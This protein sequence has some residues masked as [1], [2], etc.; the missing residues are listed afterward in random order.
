MVQIRC[1]GGRR[2]GL[3]EHRT[4]GLIVLICNRKRNFPPG[5][6]GSIAPFLS[7]PGSAMLV[8]KNMRKKLDDGL[9]SRRCSMVGNHEGAEAV[10]L[11]A[12]DPLNRDVFCGLR[13][14]RQVCNREMELCLSPV[15]PIVN[16]SCP[17]VP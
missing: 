1:V 8:D 2:F 10:R 3:R 14:T 13:S 6:G 5:H 16:R 11:R 15:V 4:V 17:I 9:R 12:S 7:I